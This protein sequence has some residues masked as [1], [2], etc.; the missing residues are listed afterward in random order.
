MKKI[1]L[2]IAIAAS[3]FAVITGCAKEENKVYLESTTK[4]TLS[5]TNV[6]LMLSFANKD[7]PLTTL[8]W[9]NPNY[10]TNT[11]ITSNTVVYLLEMD[12]LGNVFAHE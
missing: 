4:P 6:A 10:R 7:N 5:A 3:L 9:T 8:N 12:K 1:I 2:S 11:G